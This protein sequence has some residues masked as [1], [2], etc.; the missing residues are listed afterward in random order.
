MDDRFFVLEVFSRLCASR[1][2]DISAVRMAWTTRCSVAKHSLSVTRDQVVNDP[3]DSDDRHVDVC[4]QGTGVGDQPG[5]WQKV[6][7]GDAVLEAC[8]H[9]GRD[10]QKQTDAKP[11]RLTT[12]SHSATRR[13]PRRVAVTSGRSE[14]TRSN[15]TR[16]N[17][18]AAR[19]NALAPLLPSCFE[20]TGSHKRRTRPAVC[21]CVREIEARSHRD[22]NW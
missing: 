11:W 10:R 8:C 14:R 2:A 17:A 18:S 3:G 13:T 15:G 22:W 19:H 5:Q 1:N 21:S 6:Q 20:H 4:R 12:F 7:V 16:P 9:E